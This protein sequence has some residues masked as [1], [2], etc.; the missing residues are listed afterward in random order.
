[1][2]HFGERAQWRQEMLFERFKD[3]GILH[4]LFWH[5]DN[6]H[7]MVLSA[8]AVIVQYDMDNGHPL[9]YV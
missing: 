7:G 9:F 2:K 3:F 8:V 1:M 4:Q 5:D 6:L